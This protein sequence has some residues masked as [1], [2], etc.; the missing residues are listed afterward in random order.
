MRDSSTSWQKILANGFGSVA[1][2]LEFLGLPTE[3]GEPLAEQL[4]KTRVPRGF[5]ARMRPADP[6]DPLL[7]QVLAT[8]NELRVVE[9]Y[10][11]DPLQE[12]L[13]NPVPGLIH[14]YQ[15]R[16]LLIMSGACAVHC[17][18]CFRRQFPYEENNPGREGWVKAID[19]I[20]ADSR[21]DEVIFSGGDPLLV[22]NEMFD[23]LIT[24]LSFIPHVQT[25]R[26]HTRIPIVL[27][28]RIDEG[29]LN[30]LTRTRLHKVMVL[31]CNHANE[32]NAQTDEVCQKLNQSGCHLLNQSV[33][34]TGVNNNAQVL[35]SLSQRLFSTGV[36][37]YYLHV[38]DKVQGAAHF[39]APIEAVREVYQQ[40]QKLLPGYLVPRL[41]QEEPGQYQK[42]L[43]I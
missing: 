7:L 23:D 41:V 28:E 36:L 21:I 3:V 24:E 37:P 25:I 14:K 8:H 6:L 26:F 35:A 10:S 19:Y 16:V 40:L 38:L 42:T 32:L 31:H 20:K 18:Y 22:K 9:N 27:P 2:L 12:I 15:S 43:L 11:H 29:F 39:D 33:Y 17:R 1:T 13:T 5:A 34:L 4:F 30:C